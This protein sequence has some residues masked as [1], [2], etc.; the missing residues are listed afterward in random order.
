MNKIDISTSPLYIK[1]V[2]RVI[3]GE[4]HN[5]R[6]IHVCGRHCDG[7]VFIL[8]GSCHYRFDDGIEFTVKTGDILY[9]PHR[10][11][12]TMSVQSNVYRHIFCDFVF[13]GDTPRKGNFYTPQNCSDAENR[14]HKL[15]STYK[16]LSNRTFPDLLCTLYEIY[17]IILQTQNK[18]Y[19]E[20]DLKEKL[21]EAKSFL[22]RNYADPNLS[23]E[24]LAV[25]A[26]MSAVYFRRLFK[27]QYGIPPSRY[28]TSVRLKNSKELMKYPFLSLED[29]AL[30]SGF[31]SLPYF[32]RVFKEATNVTPAKFRNQKLK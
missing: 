27:E 28:L 26:N 9:L 20:K 21:E 32:C 19:R 12:Y 10:S 7:L 17:R 18:V 2:Q 16:N 13:E 24:A 29:C 6:V 4:L 25:Q 22:E 3:P 5:K 31:S 15:L 23:V 11:V 30:Q 1:N 8:E 14:F